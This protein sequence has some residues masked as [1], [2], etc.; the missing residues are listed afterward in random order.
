MKLVEH[1]KANP[2]MSVMTTFILVVATVTGAMTATGQLDALVMTEQEHNDDFVPLSEAVSGIE[3]WNRC[4]RL[5]RIL[6]SLDDRV[7]KMQQVEADPDSIRDVEKD[8]AKVARE[9]DAL[10]CAAVLAK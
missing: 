8:M 3:N 9:F 2:L 7:W 1:A 6:D 4:V 10:Q 5:E